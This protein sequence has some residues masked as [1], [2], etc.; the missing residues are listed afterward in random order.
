M[1]I[2]SHVLHIAVVLFR[3][4]RRASLEMFYSDQLHGMVAEPGATCPINKYMSLPSPAEISP[5]YVTSFRI[6][7]EINH[8]LLNLH[9]S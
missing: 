3:V 9:T 4:L 5:K 1:T 6:K 2:S 7:I 8:L